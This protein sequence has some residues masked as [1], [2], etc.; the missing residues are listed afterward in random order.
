MPAVSEDPMVE[1]MHSRLLVLALFSPLLAARQPDWPDKTQITGFPF[2]DREGEDGLPPALDEFLRAGPPPIIFTLGSSAALNPGTFFEHSVAA[3]RLLKRRAVLLVGK[4]LHHCPGSLPEGVAACAYA[5]FSLVFPRAAVLVHAG[6]IGTTGLAMRSGRP[7][8]V[9]PFA[10][11]QP[12]N[13]ARVSRL[14]IA[15]TLAPNQ[16]RPERVARELSRLS[17]SAYALR[18]EEIGQKI[19]EE[20]GVNRA[21]QA[22]ETCL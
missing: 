19:R 5:P 13:A 1:G 3:A 20:D 22:L 6:G 7:M 17:S 2:L 10:H 16:Y 18:A 8:L 21:C 14:G 9:V 4:D 11:D 15:R 12:D